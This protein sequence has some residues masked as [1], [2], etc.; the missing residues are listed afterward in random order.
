[1]TVVLAFHL[2]RLELCGLNGNTGRSLR[3]GP[4]RFRARAS[5]FNLVACKLNV[6]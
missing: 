1:V 3:N 2:Q 6:R 4:G 5:Y